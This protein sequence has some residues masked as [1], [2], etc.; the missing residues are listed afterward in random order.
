[1][2]ILIALGFYVIQP[3]LWIGVIRSY[4]IYRNRL[5]KERAIFNSAIYEDFYE[6]RHFVHFSS[7]VDCL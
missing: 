6:G 2:K 4:L 5:K 7:V 1:M 3:A